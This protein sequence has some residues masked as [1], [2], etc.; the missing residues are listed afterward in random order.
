MGEIVDNKSC[1]VCV[2]TMGKSSVG[3]P[4]CGYTVCKICI[5]RYIFSQANT[6]SV[7]HCIEMECKTP[8]PLEF[9]VH[10][11]GDQRVY[12][13]SYTKHLSIENVELRLKELNDETKLVRTVLQKCKTRKKTIGLLCPCP[14]DDCKGLV[15]IRTH[16][17][18]TCRTE[19]CSKC[20]APFTPRKKHDCCNYDL[21]T[22]D[23]LQQ[24]T[25]SCPI[26]AVPIHK[27][28]GGCDQMFCVQCH[29][30][31]SWKTR[32]VD[33]GLIHNPH[34]SHRQRWWLRVF[35]LIG[36]YYWWLHSITTPPR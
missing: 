11:F 32:Q 30:A 16:K 8:W 23:F 17:C 25:K 7:D 14:E 12:K 5:D 28:K 4:F 22:I 35:I 19:L 24:D 29:T 26:C 6:I 31:F 15:E 2:N 9:M 3:C 21:L 36:L 20:R 13:G 27:I 10:H 18:I 34:A 1:P 33:K